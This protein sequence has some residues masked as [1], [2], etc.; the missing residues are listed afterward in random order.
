MELHHSA[1]DDM[2]RPG[3][4]LYPRLEVGDGDLHCLD[5]LVFGRDGADLV[6]H[7]VS[8]YRHVLAL[9]AASG[10]RKKGFRMC[11]E[12]SCVSL[13]ESAARRLAD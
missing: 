6:A 11:K 3:L 13:S 8:L 10:F 4:V 7:L 9:D 12:N 2:P 1:G 5:L